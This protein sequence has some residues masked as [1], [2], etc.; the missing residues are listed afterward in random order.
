MLVAKSLILDP[1]S[2]PFRVMIARSDE[3]TV[4]GIARFFWSD[5]GKRHW[6]G[7]RGSDIWWEGCVPGHPKPECVC[8]SVCVCVPL[9]VEAASLEV[10]GVP[11]PP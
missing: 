9:R 3:A 11:A 7:I 8:V 10:A 2:H 4:L 5:D 1:H 6:R